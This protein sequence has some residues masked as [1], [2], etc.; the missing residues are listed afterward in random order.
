MQESL[1]DIPGAAQLAFLTLLAQSP[2]ASGFLDVRWRRHGRPMRRRFFSANDLGRAA[3]LLSRLAKC[4]DVY[5]GVALRDSDVH[6][7]RAAIGG[8]HLVWVESDDPRTAPRL[9]AFAHA[10]TMVVASGTPGHVQLYW[11][12]DERYPIEEIESANR[13]LALTLAGDAG[14]ADGARILRPPDTLNHKHDPPRPVTLLLHRPRPRYALAHLTE[15]LPMQSDLPMDERSPIQPRPERSRL[16]RELLSVPAGEY[17]RV[18]TGSSPNR[19][20]KVRCPFHEDSEPSLQL[21]PDGGFYC[22]GSRCRKGGTIFDFAAHLWGI[23]PRGVA[24]LELRNRLAK[25]FDLNSD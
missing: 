8:A 17:V 12:L 13:R 18:L 16:D 21:Y 5:V 22:F 6:G 3:Q 20:G 19:E 1:T 14:C 23:T 24:F 7:G 2:G 4:S 9:G 11:L 25:Q 10:P 15:G